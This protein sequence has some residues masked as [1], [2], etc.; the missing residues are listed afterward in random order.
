LHVEFVPL[1]IIFP[2]RLI[3]FSILFIYQIEFNIRGL[4]QL[5]FSQ[6]CLL[7]RFELSSIH[8]ER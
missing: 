7:Y 8:G 2:S 5:F 4:T 6:G 1:R 3:H